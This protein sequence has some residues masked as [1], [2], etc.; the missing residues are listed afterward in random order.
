MVEQAVEVIR[1]RVDKLGTSEPIIAPQGIS[2]SSSCRSRVPHRRSRRTRVSNCRKVAKLEFRKVTAVAAPSSKALVPPDP[3]SREIAARRNGWRVE[4]WWSGG[5]IVVRKTIDLEGKHVIRAGASFEAKGWVVHLN[6]DSLGAK[7]FGDLTTEVYNDRSALAIV[8][9][10]KVISAPGVSN[11][12]LSSAAVARSVA[13]LTNAVRATW[14]AHWRIRCRRRF[15]L[16]TS[17]VL[18]PRSA[19]TRSAAA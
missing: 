19:R 3:G 18:Q 2:I 5:E 7:V 9:D 13:A 11:G 17:E 1:K 12:T 10:G 16:K 8:L 14:L 6:F 15:R 4:S